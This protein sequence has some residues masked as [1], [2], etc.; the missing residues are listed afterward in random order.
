MS[1]ASGELR[2]R[3]VACAHDCGL[4]INPD[5]VRNQVEGNILQTLSRK[6]HEETLFDRQR[7]PT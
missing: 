5:A 7:M 1:R 4:M 3:R 6:L 2:V